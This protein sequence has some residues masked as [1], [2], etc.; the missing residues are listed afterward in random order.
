MGNIQY[1]INPHS[2]YAQNPQSNYEKDATGA[3][4]LWPATT[5]YVA[6]VPA[7]KIWQFWGGYLDGDAAE[8]IVV[9]IHDADDNQ[10]LGP[11]LSEANATVGYSYPDPALYTSQMPIPL[12]AGWYVLLTFGGAQ[13]ANAYASCIVT[14]VDAPK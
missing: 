7:G 5:T 12:L 10:L 6:T 8:T 11:L 9:T 14:E 13:G 3:T 4:T 1:N 2:F